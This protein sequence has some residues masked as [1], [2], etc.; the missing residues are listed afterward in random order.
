MLDWEGVALV[1]AEELGGVP[2]FENGAFK[3]VVV[4]LGVGLHAVQGGLYH[5]VAVFAH[6]DV[7]DE[8]AAV[9]NLPVL[10]AL[11]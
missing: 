4:Q 1:L 5:V 7:V 11:G 8:D 3:E 9:L 10:E 2:Y 6:E